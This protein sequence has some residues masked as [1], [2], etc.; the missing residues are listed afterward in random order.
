MGSRA[1]VLTTN[2]FNSSNSFQY[3]AVWAFD[4][5]VA[6]NNTTSCPSLPNWRWRASSTT[7]DLNAFT[8]QPVQHYTNPSSTSHAPNPAY[9]VSTRAGTS[10]TYRIWRI[11]NVGTGVPLLS[12]VTRT[13]SFNYSIPP[14]SP[15]GRNSTGG[16]TLIDT[17]DTRVLQAAG[18]GNRIYLSHTTGCQFTAF[19]ALEA[20]ARYVRIDH[21]IS[22]TGALGASI[23]QQA[24]L[25]GGN[26]W[27]YSYP[28]VAVNNS[29][30]VA[31]AFNVGST[32]GF[33]GSA[34][35]TKA[36]GSASFAGS[37]WLTQGTCFPNATYQASRGYN[38]SGDYTGAQTA[39]DA[40]TFWVSAERAVSISGVGCGWQTRIARLQHN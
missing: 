28:G 8:L 20:C 19:T 6:N 40:Q 29:G 38:R 9:L 5:L 4:K 16:A 30:S 2:Q 34:Y 37:F 27:Y 15:G 26:G 17:G 35:A 24:N 36:F 23:I 10:N 31:T 12:N 25:G 21:T 14:K 1:I 33:P 18:L 13:G 39:T 7:T 22:S 32:S 11:T 3:A